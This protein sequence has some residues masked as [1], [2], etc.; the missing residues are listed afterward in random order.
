MVLLLTLA[1]WFYLS[2]KH[3]EESGFLLPESA[4]NYF[5][6]MQGSSAHV[7]VLNNSVYSHTRVSL[8]LRTRLMLTSGLDYRNTSSLQ[9]SIG[10]NFYIP[11]LALWW[12]F[13]SHL[14]LVLKMER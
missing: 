4:L 8:F 6:A 13:F 5:L 2:E 10:L 11:T 3:V 9:I 1:Q 7:N 12:V 14:F